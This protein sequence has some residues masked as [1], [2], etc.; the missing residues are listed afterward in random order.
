MTETASGSA[1]HGGKGTRKGLTMRRIHTRAGVHPYDE[2]TW[3]RRDVIMTNWRDGSVNFEQRGV[4]FPDFWSVNATNIVTTKY[5]RGAVGGPEREHSLRQLVNRVVGVYLA[6]G[7]HVFPDDPIDEL[8][9][10]PLT[11][12]LADRTPEVLRGHDV[13]GV[14]GPEVGEFDAA[15]LKVDR[16]VPPVGHDDVAALPGDL[17][18]RVNALTGVDPPHREPLARALATA[19]RRPTCRLGHAVPLLGS[20]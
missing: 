20:G 10:A 9:E 13:G 2:V 14:H 15:L 5:F 19:V 3:E 18:V 7:R 6:A 4:E 16:T 11:L 12:P 17:V 1:S 8:L